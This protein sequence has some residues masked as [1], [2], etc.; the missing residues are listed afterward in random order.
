MLC[1][2]LF[3]SMNVFTY[4]MVLE[5]IPTPEVFPENELSDNVT[6]TANQNDWVPTTIVGLMIVS[7]SLIM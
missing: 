4:I 7:T 1:C 5:R 6:L 2:L 3:I